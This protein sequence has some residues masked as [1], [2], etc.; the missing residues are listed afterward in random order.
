[1][2]T[3]ELYDKN[4]SVISKFSTVAGT[5]AYMAPE[6]LKHMRDGTKP[7]KFNDMEI[8]KSQDIYSLGLILYELSHKIR[9]N[10]QKVEIF[11]ELKA[12]RK[13]KNQCP[14]I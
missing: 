1:M 10:M 13:L 7:E 3:C 14:L 12:T 4:V 9:T 11:K 5:Q 2:G 6:I 8:N